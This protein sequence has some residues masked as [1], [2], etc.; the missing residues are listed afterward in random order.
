MKRKIVLNE[1]YGAID[2]PSFSNGA[3]VLD[4]NELTSLLEETDRALQTTGIS[5]EDP[6]AMTN[7]FSE[8][9]TAGMYID[10]LAEGLNPADT[11]AFKYLCN[12]M[13]NEI[14]GTGKFNGRS[15]LKLLTEDNISAGFMPKAKLLF[16]SA[17]CFRCNV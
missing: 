3:D 7:I 12:N 17:T 15:T 14:N 2:D 16:P 1:Q 11:K 4:T 5:L 10:S 8:S 6:D 13:I 9:N